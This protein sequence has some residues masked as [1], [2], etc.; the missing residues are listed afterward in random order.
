MPEKEL[1]DDPV[2]ISKKASVDIGTVRES[3][4]SL[5]ERL[6]LANDTAKEIARNELC[7]A[8]VERL[9]L[10]EREAMEL[11]EVIALAD[12]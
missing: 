6:A 5:C 11:A 7:R 4:Q 10:A 1:S 12:K 2:A 8:L 3:L 9:E